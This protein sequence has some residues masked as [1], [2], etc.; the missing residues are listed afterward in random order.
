MIAMIS[1]KNGERERERAR[2]REREREE[3]Y[4]DTICFK[5]YVLQ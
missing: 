4:R 5:S 1:T 3:G 2:K